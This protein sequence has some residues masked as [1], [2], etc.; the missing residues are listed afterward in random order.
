[1]CE[2]AIPWCEHGDLLG[3]AEKFCMLCFEAE[4][5]PATSTVQHP[6][7][8]GLLHAGESTY[9]AVFFNTRR[10]LEVL[11]RSTLRV[12]ISTTTNVN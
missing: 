12:R 7:M 10:I 1:M 11:A 3:V 6:Y 4:K 8:W 2:G 9:I 5:A